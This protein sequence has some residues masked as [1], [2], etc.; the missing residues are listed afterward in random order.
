M[1]TIPS[2]IFT[3]GIGNINFSGGMVRMNLIT[4]VPGEKAAEQVTRLIMPVTGLMQ[5]YATMQ[6][7]MEKL[8]EAGVLQKQAATQ[9]E[10][11]Q[12]AKTS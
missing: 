7:F 6:Q 8:V 9:P 5:S 11:S 1:S 3:D 12:A 2:Q 4:L 10:V